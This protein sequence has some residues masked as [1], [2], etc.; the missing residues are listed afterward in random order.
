MSASATRGRVKEASDFLGTRCSGFA[1]ASIIG[2]GGKTAVF[3]GVHSSG[4]SAAVRVLGSVLVEV[5]GVAAAYRDA[6]YDV[7]RIADAAGMTHAGVQMVQDDDDEPVPHL[8]EELL[9]GA[10]LDRLTLEPLE[11]LRMAHMTL[12]VLAAAHGKG[13]AHRDVSAR[14]LFR[15]SDGNLKVLG[16]GTSGGL[17]AMRARSLARRKG[18]PPVVTQAEVHA[19]VRDVSATFLALYC[20]ARCE[21]SRF[22]HRPDRRLAV[23]AVLE[24]GL[25]I[26]SSVTPWSALEMQCALERAFE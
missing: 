13:V 1:L 25:A 26:A 22:A 16:L 9:E 24:R 3:R 11:I 18:S 12:G 14:K 21:S 5:P 2:V 15:T 8:V 10:T 7:N 6:A 17:E 19:D 23:V 20:A 4:F